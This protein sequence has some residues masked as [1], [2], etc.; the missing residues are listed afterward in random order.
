MGKMGKQLLGKDGQADLLKTKFCHHGLYCDDRGNNA[1][2]A[3]SEHSSTSSYLLGQA[4]TYE[5]LVSVFAERAGKAYASGHDD[6]AKFFRDLS[7]EMVLLGREWRKKQ[8]QH[9][10]EYPHGL[11]DK[12]KES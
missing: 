2:E 11:A 6:E 7:K 5:N 8:R 3:C 1:C 9:D 10:E 12:K 4:V